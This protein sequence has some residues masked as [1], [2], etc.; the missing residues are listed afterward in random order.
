MTVCNFQLFRR[1]SPD[2]LLTML[3]AMTVLPVMAMVMIR[4]TGTSIS[5]IPMFRMPSG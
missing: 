1:V 3:A 2:A 5:T 4:P